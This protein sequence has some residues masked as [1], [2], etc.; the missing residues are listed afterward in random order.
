MKKKVVSLAIA[1]MISVPLLVTL[2]A[3]AHHGLQ[4]DYWHV[5]WG[6]N[7]R[8]NIEY[9]VNKSN[10]SGGA[11]NAA[12]SIADWNGI[13]SKVKI[14]PRPSNSKYANPFL[15]IVI[16]S[17]A[18]DSW[19]KAT[20][21]PVYSSSTDTTL[22]WATATINSRTIEQ[23]IKEGTSPQVRQKVI[24]HEIGHTLGLAH[25]S[26]SSRKSI[27]KQGWH[28]YNNVQP[29]DV[30]WINFR[31]GSNSLL[32]SNI[33]TESN[34]IAGDHEQDFESYVDWVQY[35][36]LEEM[37]DSS[38]LIIKA[39]ENS[40]TPANRIAGEE[41]STVY[42]AKASKIYKGNIEADEEIRIGIMGGQLQNGTNYSILNSEQIDPTKPQ[43]LFLKKVNPEDYS[44]EV[45]YDYYLVGGP[46]GIVNDSEENINLNFEKNA[47]IPKIEF[48]EQLK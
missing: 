44:Y 27:M 17:K 25:P 47:V 38:D 8:N 22:I 15:N 35:E 42:E 41:P 46:A 34:S 20:T 19:G 16:D 1:M 13:Q 9:V 39:T 14:V 7:I 18:Y 6:T 30:T 37:I 24:T 23:A 2:P 5:Y 32:S 3:S 29:S 10:T 28:D 43:F 4:N 12:Y 31:Y 26:D 36:S 40:K 45:P 48:E 11:Y 33:E 21:N